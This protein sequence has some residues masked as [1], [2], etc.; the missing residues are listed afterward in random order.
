[1]ANGRRMEGL[2]IMKKTQLKQSGSDAAKT[3][4]FER[5]SDSPNDY[6]ARLDDSA[7]IEIEIES[8]RAGCGWLHLGGK[9]RRY[10]TARRDQR[11]FVWLDGYSYTFDIEQRTARRVGG[12][13]AA[14]GGGQLNAPMPGTILKISVAAGDEVEAGAAV[15]VMESMKMEMT[16][17]APSA[18]TVKEIHCKVGQ[19]VEVDQLLASLEPKSDA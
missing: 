19:L 9:V 15:I 3:V 17:T 11:V 16:L 8:D 14:V 6:V 4:Q 12:S 1:M 18:G 10:Q 2:L 13:A 5:G 7:A